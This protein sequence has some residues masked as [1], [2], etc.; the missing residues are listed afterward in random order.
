MEILYDVCVEHVNVVM[1]LLK[2]VSTPHFLFNK[3]EMIFGFCTQLFL[4]FKLK[5]FI[6]TNLLRK[7]TFSHEENLP[8]LM[9]ANTCRTAASS[10]RQL[11]ASESREELTSVKKA[12]QT[13]T[14][15]A[16][17]LLNGN[18]VQFLNS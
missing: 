15:H 3:G 7:N 18:Y 5:M 17:K 6:Q 12:L 10:L 8:C 14:K 11:M 4:I 1:S 2:S 9:T 16:L 13:S